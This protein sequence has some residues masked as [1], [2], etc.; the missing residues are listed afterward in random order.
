MRVFINAN[1]GLASRFRTTIEFE[2]YTDDELVAILLQLAEG[3]D[4]ELVPEAV[5]RFREVLGGPRAASTFGNGRFAR[6][7]LEAAIGQHAW[8]LR[9]IESPTRDQLRQLV[10]RDFDAEPL[11]E[12]RGFRPRAPDEEDASQEPELPRPGPTSGGGP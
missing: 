7:A 5:E 2:D 3:A 12:A 6:N 10:A 8:R 1:P 9:D 4:Y 11:E